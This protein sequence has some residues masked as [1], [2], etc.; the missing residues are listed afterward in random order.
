M[1]DHKSADRIDIH[2]HFIPSFYR[3]AL[4]EAGL[5]TPDGIESLPEWTEE[6]ALG[7]MEQLGV[8]TSVVSISSPGVH[9]GHDGR[10]RQLCRRI[11]DYGAD[12]KTRHKGRFGHFAS[13]PLPDIDGSIEEAIR[14]LDE[15]HAD[16]VVV[17]SNHHGLYL[18]DEKL[19]PFWAA[20]N[21]RKAVVFVHPTSP[22]AVNSERISKK[23]PETI[24]EFFFDTSR[25]FVD[26]VTA[27]VL[28]RYPE[29]KFIVPHA[30][31]VLPI[32]TNRVDT[33]LQMLKPN[34][35]GEPTPTLREAMRLLHFD[36]AGLP[37]PELLKGLLDLSDHSRLHYGSDAPFTKPAVMVELLDKLE[38]TPLVSEKVRTEM[39][40]GN[41]RRLLPSLK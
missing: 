15:L 40:G 12:L 21:E 37:I 31:S 22:P 30:G 2:A 26:I 9:F 1:L 18:G 35:D 7:T 36:L 28:K 14:A 25:S 6:L 13:V 8:R 20:L 5:A 27:G 17:Q 33:G 34:S 10:S 39:F 11:N 32:L 19:E 16:G 4:Q 3:A 29:L 38:N 24:L 41:A 23:I